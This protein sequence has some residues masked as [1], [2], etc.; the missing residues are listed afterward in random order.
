MKPNLMIP[1]LLSPVS[2]L[3]VG[4]VDTPSS[5][6]ASEPIPS[7]TPEATPSA[8]SDNSKNSTNIEKSWQDAVLLQF[9]AGANL[10]GEITLPIGVEVTCVTCYVKGVMTTELIL[11][12]NFDISQA[13]ANFTDD[14][15]EEIANVTEATI[16]YLMDVIPDLAKNL[17]DDFDFDDISFPPLN[18]SLNLDIPDIPECGLHFEFDGLELYLLTDIALSTG[19]TYTINLYPGNT[20]IGVAIDSQTLIGVTTPIDLILSVDAPVSVNITG[21]L[22]I[23]MNDGLSLDVALFAQEIANVTLTGGSFE[24]LPVTVQGGGG[25]GAITATLRVGVHAGVSFDSESVLHS[26]QLNLLPIAA[27]AQVAVYADLAEFTTNITAAAN[28]TDGDDDCKLRVQQG[29]Q[30]ALGAAAG[31]SLALGPQTWGPEPETSIPIFYTTFVDDCIESR[32]ATAT[33]TLTPTPTIT[34]RADED[35]TTTTLRET[36]TRS[37]L[38]CLSTGL[39]NCPLSL[40]SMATGVS[41]TTLVVTVPSGSKATFPTTTDSTVSETVPFGKNSKIIAATTGSPVSYVPPPP[42]PPPP[43][44]TTSSGATKVASNNDSNESRKPAGKSGAESAGVNK[45]LVIGLSVGLG[46]PFLIAVAAGLYFFMRRRR[47]AAVAEKDATSSP[48]RSDST[49]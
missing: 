9:D 23:K 30:F 26:D 44:T 1:F 29:Y 2:L 41:T 18:V 4:A 39:V 49:S 17:T 8:G 32:T 16:D 48:E 24:F 22:H 15:G 3:V 46:V 21:G 5:P 12:R 25:P 34:A 20:Q 11:D 37:N 33:P 31:A 38:V 19:T 27:G 7:A 10:V 14:V 42:P 40:Q 36:V 28:G 43:A 47:Y 6:N 45:P 35:M 13:I